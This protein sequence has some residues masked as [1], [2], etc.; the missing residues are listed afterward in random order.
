MLE[1]SKPVDVIENEHTGIS[2]F[3]QDDIDGT[4]TK[5]S[6]RN[7]ARKSISRNFLGRN[8]QLFKRKL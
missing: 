6:L 5:T 8:S 2:T 3:N 1:F 7:Q 4:S